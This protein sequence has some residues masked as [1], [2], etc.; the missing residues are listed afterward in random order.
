MRE[1]GIAAFCSPR[2]VSGCNMRAKISTPST[3]LR[4]AEVGVSVHG[5]HAPLLHRRELVPA[6]ELGE[7]AES[8]LCGAPGVEAAGHQDERLWGALKDLLPL[9]PRR[10]LARLGEDLFAAGDA[11]HLGE[12]VPC[13]EG[14]VKP[15][16]TPDAGAGKPRD[17]F[18]YPS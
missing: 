8:L 15:F 16:D 18:S 2:K 13:G 9:N 12:P 10:G 6:G 3:S 1:N 14:R 4:A 17:G 11:N 7:D 5:P